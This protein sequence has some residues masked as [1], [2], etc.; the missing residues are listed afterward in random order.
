MK[1]SKRIWL[2]CQ[3]QIWTI[4]WEKVMDRLI[5][6][7][8]AQQSQEN[9]RRSKLER[10]RPWLIIRLI[11]QGPNPKSNSQKKRTNL[12]PK[13]NRVRRRSWKRNN[14][15]NR[16]EKPRKTKGL[17]QNRIRKNTILK[18]TVKAKKKVLEKQKAPKR[19]EK[20]WK[21]QKDLPARVRTKNQTR[22]R[23]L[24]VKELKSRKA[25]EQRDQRTRTKRQLDQRR[26]HQNPSQ[27][28]PREQHQGQQKR[29]QKKNLQ[30]VPQ[31]L[32]KADNQ[33]WNLRSKTRK[34]ENLMF[35]KCRNP[36]TVKTVAAMIELRPGASPLDISLRKSKRP[37]HVF[38]THTT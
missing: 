30:E 38:R 32:E 8:Q 15:R 9:P 5:F 17:L 34:W 27:K 26:M 29:P 21:T 13:K 19:T 24:K 3:S 12:L 1:N 14:R 20:V 31:N 36:R 35:P 23:Q 10:H 2:I 16:R 6:Q 37:D 33:K 7:N 11:S 25:K 4:D 22:K 28:V 18:V